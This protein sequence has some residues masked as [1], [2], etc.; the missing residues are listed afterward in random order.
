MGI[1]SW[2]I[3]GYGCG[4]AGSGGGAGGGGLN[5]DSKLCEIE[6]RGPSWGK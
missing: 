4:R 2:I 1:V 6:G 3:S 5:E